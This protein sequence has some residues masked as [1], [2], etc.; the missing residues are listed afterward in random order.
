MLLFWWKLQSSNPTTDCTE[1]LLCCCND[2]PE[3]CCFVGSPIQ[4]SMVVHPVFHDHHR[5]ALH[6]M[7]C[8]H[9]HLPLSSASR[10]S[11]KG[12]E[13]FREKNYRMHPPTATLSMQASTASS[14]HS[15]KNSP[16]ESFLQRTALMAVSIDQCRRVA[17]LSL[18][19]TQLGVGWLVLLW[20]LSFWIT[21]T[22]T[23]SASNFSRP[24]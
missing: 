9:S 12:K 21:R 19:F 11:W 23:F 17:M 16:W 8:F 7:W 24:L 1:R 13:K 4:S 3:N 22:G 6:P 5:A 14:L 15:W 10:V 20:V 2:F 18:A